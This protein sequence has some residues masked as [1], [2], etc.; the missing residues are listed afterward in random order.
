M[1]GLDFK[2]YSRLALVLECCTR[3]YYFFLVAELFILLSCSEFG[4]ALSN[5]LSIRTEMSSACVH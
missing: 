4:H 5:I 1:S 2:A 3:H